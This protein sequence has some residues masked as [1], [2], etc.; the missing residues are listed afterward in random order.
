MMLLSTIALLLRMPHWTMGLLSYSTASP[1]CP[2]MCS[3]KLRP[4]TAN[5]F[6][7]LSTQPLGSCHQFLNQKL[8]YS[9]VT[10]YSMNISTTLQKRRIL[11]SLTTYT[12]MYLL[13]TTKPGPTKPWPSAGQDRKHTTKVQTSLGK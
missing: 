12:N 11:C 6:R 10:A 1:Q 8:V 5:F 3:M 9:A 4:H 2:Y 7:G 13:F